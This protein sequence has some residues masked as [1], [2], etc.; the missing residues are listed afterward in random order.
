M[1]S[2]DAVQQSIQ[3]FHDLPPAFAMHDTVQAVSPERFN[4]PGM[5]TFKDDSA[6]LNFEESQLIALGHRPE[7]K[8]TH[9]FEFDGISNDYPLLM[10]LQYCDVLLCLH[11]WWASIVG[12]GNVAE[13]ESKAR[14]KMKLVKS[15]LIVSI[16]Q[17]LVMAS[18]SKYCNI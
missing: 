2:A 10:E 9:T 3:L 14:L 13:F 15:R 17:L 4:D 11:A 5:E 16:G 1:A 6:G 7:L 8:R 12:L 18:L